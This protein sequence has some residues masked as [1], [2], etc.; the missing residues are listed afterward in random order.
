M[1]RALLGV[2][3]VVAAA[4]FVPLAGAGGSFDYVTGAGE[5]ATES[6]D[7]VNHFAVNAQD[8]PNGVVGTY[9]AESAAPGASSF[10]VEVKCMYVAGNRALIGGIITH[11]VARPELDGVGFAVAFEDNGS[12]QG[13]TT[14]DRVSFSDFFVEPGRT[15]PTTQ[16]DCAAEAASLLQYP[17]QP[18]AAGN[19]TVSDAP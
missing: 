3:A 4:A 18:M 10:D 8:G 16:A 17:F 5:R 14:P 7:L 15:P 9:H 1:N 12:P 2:A 6:G 11:E 13:G 19:V